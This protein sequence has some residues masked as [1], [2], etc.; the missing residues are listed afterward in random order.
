MKGGV[1]TTWHA[2]C[3][4]PGL[5]PFDLSHRLL[6]NATRWIAELVGDCRELLSHNGVACYGFGTQQ[7]LHLPRHRPSVVVAAVG[8]ERPDQRALLALRSQVG[9]DPQRRV[10]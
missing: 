4:Y 6:G 10:R 7:S 8:G 2:F 1:K 3:F 9:V 5:Y